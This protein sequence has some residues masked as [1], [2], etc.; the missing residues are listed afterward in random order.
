MVSLN[1]TGFK[2]MN[3]QGFYASVFQVIEQAMIFIVK[4]TVTLTY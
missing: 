1:L 3:G 4:V 2:L